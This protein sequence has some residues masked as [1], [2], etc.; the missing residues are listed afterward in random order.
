MSE[1]TS[2]KSGMKSTA[3][4]LQ[5]GSRARF[6]FDPAPASHKVPGAFGKEDPGQVTS[7]GGRSLN[8]NP[9]L[10]NRPKEEVEPETNEENQ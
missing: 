7:R 2:R 8:V 10:S 9:D 5:P 6:G 4:K 1:Q 3:K